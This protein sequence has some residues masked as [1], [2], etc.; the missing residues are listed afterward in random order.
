MNKT[1]AIVAQDIKDN[2]VPYYAETLEHYEKMYDTTCMM[3]RQNLY[4]DELAYL[5]KMLE[6]ITQRIREIV[7]IYM[8]TRVY[9]I[10][11]GYMH[12][13]K[14][15]NNVVSIDDLFDFYKATKIA[16]ACL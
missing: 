6:K 2:N 16:N 1:I 12:H 8:E 13:K 3:M 7:I 11:K 4:D 9:P 14:V 10:V 15:T 5:E